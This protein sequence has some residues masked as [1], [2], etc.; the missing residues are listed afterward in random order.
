MFS[1]TIL[2]FGSLAFVNPAEVGT[3]PGLDIQVPICRLCA[4]NTTNG[5]VTI[6]TTDIVLCNEDAL[7]YVDYNATLSDPVN[8]TLT[9]SMDTD[10][11]FLALNSVTGIISGT[12]NNDEVGLYVINITATT[13]KGERD[14]NLHQ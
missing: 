10:A 4:R 13:D 1:I 9:W 12:P 3:I 14:N 6:T 11:S 8:D 2:C 7:Y 5:T